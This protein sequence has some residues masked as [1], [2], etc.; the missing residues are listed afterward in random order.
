M[1]ESPRFTKSRRRSVFQACHAMPLGWGG[2]AST[3]GGAGPAGA[4]SGC[5]QQERPKCQQQVCPA[6]VKFGSWF[7]VRP[8]PG[9]QR[10]IFSSS[11]HLGETEGS[12]VFS[13]FIRTLIPSPGL[14][15]CDLIPPKGPRPYVILSGLG[16]GSKHSV[17]SNL[18]ST[19]V[20][21]PTSLTESVPGT[22]A[23]QKE[24][25]RL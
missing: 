17:Q 5:Q 6:H 2:R 4:V 13:S 14:H 25:T 9:V 22:H 1:E 21:R 8:L 19:T 11:S 3:P 7:L 15:P 24:N 12:C 20:C 16:F 23:I 10:A 18:R